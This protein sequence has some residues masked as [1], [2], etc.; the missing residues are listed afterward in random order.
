MRGL[1]QALQQLYGEKCEAEALSQ[2]RMLSMR[3]QM[4]VEAEAGAQRQPELPLG[5]AR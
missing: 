4:R 2:E 1:A 5:V 3:E